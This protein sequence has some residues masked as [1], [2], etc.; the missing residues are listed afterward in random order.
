MLEPSSIPFRLLTDGSFEGFLTAV[1][2]AF[3]LRLPVAGIAAEDIYLPSL[4][5][6]TRSIASDP[7]KARRVWTALAERD[8]TGAAMVRAAFLSGLPGI[9]DA[10]WRA[11]RK[12]FQGLPLRAILDE[13]IQTVYQAA[14]K[15]RGEIHAFL[16][17]VRFEKASDGTLFSVIAPDYDIVAALGPHFCRRFPEETW[18]IAD[19]KRGLCLCHW[20]G[21]TELRRCDPAA[22][23]RSARDAAQLASPEDARWQDLWRS[24]Y[25]SIGIAERKNPRLMA[26]NLPR[27]YW[28]Y[29]PERQMANP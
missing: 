9:E 6:P 7:E 17:L 18:M 28:R 12:F 8:A 11:L 25:R 23:P 14:W 20:Q 5:E 21:H 15:V 27:K 29:L 4:L 13:D 10:L 1:F 19:S 24:Y 2:E 26:R 16:G 3:R 22:L